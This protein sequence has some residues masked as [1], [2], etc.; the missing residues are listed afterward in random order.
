MHIYLKIKLIYRYLE[1]QV[2]KRVGYIPVIPKAQCTNICFWY[3]P[4]SIRG[5]VQ[6]KEWWTA[7]GKVCILKMS[8]F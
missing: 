1:E 4:P 7:V 3:I 2:A 8:I 5:Q 6:T